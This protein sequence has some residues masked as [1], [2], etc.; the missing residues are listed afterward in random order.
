M[1]LIRMIKL[2]GWESKVR[3]SVEKKREEELV[4]HKKKLL[5]G[6]LSMNAK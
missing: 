5:W 1:S 3:T 4:W 6:L 2:F